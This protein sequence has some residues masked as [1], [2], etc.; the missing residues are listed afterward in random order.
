MFDE[1]FTLWAWDQNLRVYLECEGPEF[2]VTSN[3]LHWLSLQP[4]LDACRIK[5]VLP[6]TERAACFKIEVWARQRQQIC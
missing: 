3:I 2:L 1:Q 5:I 6:N 4:A